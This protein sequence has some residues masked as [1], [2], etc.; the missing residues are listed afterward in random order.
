MGLGFLLTGV[1][2]PVL[3]SLSLGR[4]CRGLTPLF[5]LARWALASCPRALDHSSWRLVPQ[6]S[7]AFSKVKGYNFGSGS[8]WVVDNALQTPQHGFPPNFV[9]EV[10]CESSPWSRIFRVSSSSGG[11]KMEQPSSKCEEKMEVRSSLCVHTGKYR[12]KMKIHI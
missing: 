6:C 4:R 9:W 8:D 1:Q 10:D 3:G 12:Q 2:Q 11:G 5:R 7:C